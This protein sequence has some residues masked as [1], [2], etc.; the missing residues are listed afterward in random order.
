[1]RHIHCWNY[2]WTAT[3]KGRKADFYDFAKDALLSSSFWEHWIKLLP[4]YAQIYLHVLIINDGKGNGNPLQNS[5]LEN[6]RER[7]A[8]WAAVYG[9]AQ[10]R[11]PLKWLSSSIINDMMMSS[12]RSLLDQQNVCEVLSSMFLWNHNFW[13]W[14]A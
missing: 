8:W 14:L 5:C 1:M 6:P 3:S 10:S 4:L 9:V 13:I 7:G 2:L 12:T 11:T